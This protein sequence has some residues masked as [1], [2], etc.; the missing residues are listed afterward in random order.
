MNRHTIAAKK[1][2]D[3]ILTML[4]AWCVD[5]GEDD[6]DL[7]EFDHING[8]DYDVAKLSYR[9]RMSRYLQEAK[10]KKICVCCKDCNL[11]RR[12]R[13]DNGRFVPTAY[14]VPL[15]DNIPF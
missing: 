8:R 5:C 15:T 14:P 11:K 9:H 12:K 7:L 3:Q 10:A 13:N 1:L 4:G 6:R 2:R